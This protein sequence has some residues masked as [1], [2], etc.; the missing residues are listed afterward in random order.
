[1]P[2]CSPVSLRAELRTPGLVVHRCAGSPCPSRGGR[3][4]HAKDLDRRGFVRPGGA[5]PPSSPHEA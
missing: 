1:M 2:R 5:G 3:P 4:L